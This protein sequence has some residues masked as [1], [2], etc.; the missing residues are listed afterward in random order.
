MVILKDNFTEVFDNTLRKH[1]IT[2]SQIARFTRLDEGYISKLR[3]GQKEN[4]SDETIFKICFAIAYY[5][6]KIPLDDLERLFNTTG[7]SLFTNRNN[8][9]F[10][11]Y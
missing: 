9:R 5:A 10:N 3:N 2:G 11:R 1:G 6:N 4:P 8:S 7:H